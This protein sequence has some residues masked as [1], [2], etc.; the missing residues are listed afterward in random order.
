MLINRWMGRKFHQI[1][2]SKII[3]HKGRPWWINNM[4]CNFTMLLEY[5][6]QNRFRC[7]E[8]EYKVANDIRAHG[9]PMEHQVIYL[10]RYIADLALPRAK[11]I[12]EL[13]GP[14]HDH[15]LQQDKDAVRKELFNLFGFTYVTWKMP[16]SRDEY[17]KKMSYFVKAYIDYAQPLPLRPLTRPH[18]I[19]KATPEGMVQKALKLKKSKNI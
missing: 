9:L 15:K 17:D 6:Q 4:P 2:E 19:E 1:V 10:N 18:S 3:D 5:A 13:D 12:L 16:M 14:S 8:Y 11:L 7:P